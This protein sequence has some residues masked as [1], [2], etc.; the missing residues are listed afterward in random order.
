MGRGRNRETAE[1]EEG[2]EMNKQEWE[3]TPKQFYAAR[4]RAVLDEYP[5]ESAA[6]AHEC[7]AVQMDEYRD[8]LL[9][10]AATGCRIPD[11]VLDRL[12]RAECW[13]I[14]H[15]PG[16]LSARLRHDYPDLFAGYMPPDVRRRNNAVEAEWRAAIRRGREAA[17]Q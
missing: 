13:P 14:N 15:P 16:G 12:D 4:Y 5:D 2:E 3:M 11:R 9:R 1:D 6:V 7:A 10:A 17:N 8:V